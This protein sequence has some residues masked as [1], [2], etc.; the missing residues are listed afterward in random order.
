MFGSPAASLGSLVPGIDKK[1]A[2]IV[3]SF[4]DSKG[5]SKDVGVSADRKKDAGHDSKEKAKETSEVSVETESHIEN[6]SS[7]SDVHKTSTDS[8]D[9]SFF[10]AYT[11]SGTRKLPVL[12]VRGVLA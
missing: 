4:R 6:R 5:S 1:Q 9:T 7:H 8:Q 12:C 10:G 2:E 3:A 11:Y